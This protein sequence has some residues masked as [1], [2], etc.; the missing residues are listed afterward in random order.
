MKKF[1]VAVATVG[2]LCAPF[3]AFADTITTPVLGGADP[4]MM[5][6][7]WGLTGYQTP[8]FAS[9]TTVVDEHNIVMGCPSWFPHA[10]LGECQDISHTAYYRTSLNTAA[11]AV[12][13]FY[14]SKSIALAHTSTLN[15][16]I[17]AQ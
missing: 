5:M 13:A 1:I 11:Q 12:I 14:G 9:G 6:M 16:W 10:A 7:V 15:G 8:H 4:N 17:S 2:L 3:A